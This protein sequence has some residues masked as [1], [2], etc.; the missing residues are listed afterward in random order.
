MNHSCQTA[1][2]FVIIISSR[3]QR[4]ILILQSPKPCVILPAVVFAVW[5]VGFL[6]RNGV[7]VR[8]VQFPFTPQG[9]GDSL[10][11]DGNAR[12]F[13]TLR[14]G[15][16][17]I[18]VLVLHRMKSHNLC[19]Q[20]AYL[21]HKQNKQCEI[22]RSTN[23]VYV[24]WVQC[25]TGHCKLVITSE[26]VQEEEVTQES[27]GDDQL[28]DDREAHNQQQVARW[29]GLSLR[30]YKQKRTSLIYKKCSYKRE[31]ISFSAKC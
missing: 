9:G 14:R 1:D 3:R 17:L 24:W 21:C 7:W 27:R 15:N 25:T 10:T 18:S 31:I 6:G 12:N 30:V 28:D 11:S 29:T 16:P 19:F 26:V 23:T 5:F 8:T 20:T 2:G 22:G 13:T 4:P